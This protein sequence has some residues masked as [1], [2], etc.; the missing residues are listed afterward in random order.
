[1]ASDQA[2]VDFMF[3]QLQPAGP[4]SARKMFGEYGLYWDDQGGLD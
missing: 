4:V 2:F 1:M 3:D